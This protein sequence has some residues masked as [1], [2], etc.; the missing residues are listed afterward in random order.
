MTQSSLHN[1]SQSCLI[2]VSYDRQTLNLISQNLKINI[3]SENQCFQEIGLYAERWYSPILLGGLS[4]STPVMRILELE[5]ESFLVRLE[6]VLRRLVTWRPE[7]NRFNTLDWDRPPWRTF[8]RGRHVQTDKAYSMFTI[9]SFLG[10]LLRY[11]PI[12]IRHKW[13]IVKWS[14]VDL[15][16]LFCQYD[17]E[18]WALQQPTMA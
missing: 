2:S 9:V 13:S 15:S 6:M 5:R 8:L 4:L 10:H 14:N 3:C 1:K 11:Y 16:I 12:F 18:L 7:Q 17:G